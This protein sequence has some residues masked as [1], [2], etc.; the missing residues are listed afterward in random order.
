MILLSI[1]CFTIA[2]D[3]PIFSDTSF[4][5]M[6]LDGIKKAIKNVLSQESIFVE[7]LSKVK[8]AQAVDPTPLHFPLK[9]MRFEV[10]GKVQGVFFRKHTKE[11]AD[12]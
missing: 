11:T 8:N 5:D 2:Q 12:S 4:P 3:M 1:I 6:Q 10:F 9:V 7:R